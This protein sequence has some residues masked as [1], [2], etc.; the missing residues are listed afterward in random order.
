MTTEDEIRMKLGFDASAVQRG[1]QAMLDQQKKASMDYVAFW[2]T[3]AQKRDAIE[4][5]SND[6]SLTR[7]KNNLAQ[8]ARLQKEWLENQAA[9]YEI[10]RGSVPENMNSSG[11][12]RGRTGSVGGSLVGAQV[13]TDLESGSSTHDVVHGIELY[14]EVAAGASIG[15]RITRYVIRLVTEAFEAVSSAIAVS[16]AGIAATVLTGVAATAEFLPRLWNG[17]TLSGT[18]AARKQSE[19]TGKDLTEKIDFTAK[20]LR[21]KVEKMQKSGVLNESQSQSAFSDLTHPTY[22]SVTRVQLLTN[23]L[24][25]QQKAAEK[26]VEHNRAL[27]VA[28]KDREESEKIIAE[29]NEKQL[30]ATGQMN[31]EYADLQN[32]AHRIREDYLKLDQETPT[33]GDLAGTAFTRQINK[34]Y[35]T[36]GKYDLGKGDGPFAGIAQDALLAQ[37]QQQWDIIHGNA[38]FDK[39]GALIGGTAFKDRQRQMADENKLGAAG[40]QTPAMKMDEMKR[41]LKSIADSM[42]ELLRRADQEGLA[43]KDSTAAT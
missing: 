24:L 5:A 17:A 19:S 14:A 3:A 18:W 26:L 10:A 15:S 32:Q 23:S 42:T 31:K 9:Q 39:S 13:A 35:G 28:D 36:G 16:A 6:A 7:L 21:E 30:R 25:E 27:A 34:N 2:Q 12:A 41:E 4:T 8:K 11:R 40:L 29:E 1:T 22:E 37:K 33:I 20:T 38:I 43:I